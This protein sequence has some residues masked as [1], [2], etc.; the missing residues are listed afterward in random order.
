MKMMMNCF[1]GMIDWQK[2]FIPYF[3][4]EP[5][6]EILTIA[7]LWKEHFLGYGMKILN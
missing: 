3:Q 6:Q 1:C 5:L 2:A 4:P 7:N